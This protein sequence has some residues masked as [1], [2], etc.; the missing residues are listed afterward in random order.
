M[1]SQIVLEA[2]RKKLI[3]KTLSAK[4]IYSIMDELAHDRLG[5]V[6]T[7]YF[8][9][10]GL[11][12]GFSEEELYYLTK[13]MVET[14]EKIKFEGI[15]ADKHSTGGVAGGRTTMILVPIIAACGLKIPKTSSRAITSPAGTA[16]TMEVLAPVTFTAERIKKMVKEVGGC[17]VWAG[18]INLAPADDVLIQVEKPLQFESFDKIIISVLA[19]KVACGVTHVVL[20]IPVGPTMKIQRYE[21][22]EKVGKKFLHLASRLKMKID[23]D[24][25]YTAE[26]TAPGLGPVLEARD[27]LLVLE[28]ASN[29]PR[30]LEKKALRLTGKL[31]DLCL[32]DPDYK[33]DANYSA[34][35]KTYQAAR[36]NGEIMARNILESGKALLRMKEIIK[37]QG[38]EPEITSKQLKPASKTVEI[39]SD[40]SG[41]V[42]AV[43]NKGLNSLCRLLGTP[44][45]KKAGIYLY[46][47]I[48]ET[49]SMS[50][51]LYQMYTT[52]SWKLKEAQETLKIV[53]VYKIE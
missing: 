29:R 49:V 45:D 37:I 10:A 21:D 27:A 20:D 30:F 7:T 17:I 18:G 24:V 1:T 14:G 26:P 16:D 9:A 19:K 44:E 11:A 33:D 36:E 12:H 41:K 47:R 6:F 48:G 39:K 46:K 28:Q 42:S 3:G 50:E 43:N 34:I 8:A 13:A 23:L 25:N 40:R 4:E 35:R 38:G 32:G 52:D 22:A 15:V 31:L 5:P 51:P 53:E 2:I